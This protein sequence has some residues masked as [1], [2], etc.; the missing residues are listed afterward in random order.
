MDVELGEI[1][2]AED[3]ELAQLHKQNN[4]FRDSWIGLGDFIPVTDST[5]FETGNS[6][7][8]AGE[9]GQIRNNP[10]R[11]FGPTINASN[12]IRIELKQLMPTIADILASMQEEIMQ[13]GGSIGD[14]AV[15]ETSVK[16]SKF[17]EM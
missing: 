11:T 9:Y 3:P 5:H 1:V 6:V 16:I 13:S 15:N 10:G 17:A 8:G 12:Q 4:Y 7:K 14:Y 2:A